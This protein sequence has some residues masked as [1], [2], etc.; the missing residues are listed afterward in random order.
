MFESKK[1]ILLDMN[2]TFMFGED[3]FGSDEDYSEYYH[4]I[5]GEL[6]K[7]SIN[8]LIAKVYA[9]LDL[10]YPDQRYRDNFP[11][12]KEAISAVADLSL[13]HSEIDRIINTFSFHEHGH[14]PQQYV[15][16]LLALAG[17]FTLAA[18]IDIWAPKERWLTTFSD[19]GIDG[20]FKAISFSS[21]HGVVKPSPKPFRRIVKAL[22]CREQDCLVIGDSVRRDLG[23]ASA[24]GV[25]CVLVGGVHD[26][27]A[28]AC[29]PNLLAFKDDCC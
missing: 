21:D 14:I 12:V 24:A 25:D 20:L 23:G 9:Y 27:R 11:S 3:R 16:T 28:I 6:E 15:E 2:G 7:C 18:V 29:Y 19:R 13:S 10:R 8:R 17:R 4:G 22:G 5:G 26:S 1:A